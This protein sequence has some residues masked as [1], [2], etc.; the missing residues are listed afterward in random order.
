[1]TNEDMASL[2]Q[3]QTVNHYLAASSA[4]LGVAIVGAMGHPLMSLLSVPISVYAYS[5]ILRAG[6]QA[7]FKER[8]LRA[9]VVDSM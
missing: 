3:R 9:A 8:R 5:D 2:K 7:L 1:M 4:G 6:Y